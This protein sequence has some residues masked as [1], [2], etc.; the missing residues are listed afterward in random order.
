MNICLIGDGLTNLVLAKILANKNISI[1]VC[2]ESKKTKKSTS[3]TIGISKNNFDFFKSNIIDI[4]KISWPINY[5]QIFNEL[6]QIEEILNFKSTDSQLFFIVKHSELYELVQ[7]DIKKNKFIKK[8]KIKKSFDDEII[9]NNK[10]DLI[11]NSETQNKISKKIFFKRITKDYK[12]VAFT[13]IVKHQKCINNKAVQIFT[14]CG[15]LAFLPYSNTETSIVFS[16]LDEKKNKSE[17]EIKELIIKYN[18]YYKINSFKNFEKYNLKFSILRKYYHKNILCFG[19]N[20]HNI[21]PLA[22]QGFNMT[23]RDI[24]ILS[25]LID[26][27]IDLGLPLDSSIL[28]EFESKTKHL[29]YIF[30]S[31]INFIHEFFKFDNKYGNNYSKEILKYLGKNNLFNK[32]ISK[33]ADQGLAL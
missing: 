14:S 23:L 2:F 16:V 32:Y 20:L 12:S 33:F 22:G 27:K 19:D 10:F 6:N 7:K 18:K 26:E 25:D 4:K 9:E 8:I 3:R 1:S 24:K 31:G 5:I 13:T 17:K 15:P 21:H 11:I 29:N 30:S 28:K